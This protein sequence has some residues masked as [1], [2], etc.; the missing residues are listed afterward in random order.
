LL[1]RPAKIAI[2]VVGIERDK[3]QQ[4][5]AL[6]WG[7]TVHARTHTHTSSPNTGSLFYL[8]NISGHF[9]PLSKFAMSMVAHI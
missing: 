6:Y 8:T 2:L 5:V 7:L 4:T 9:P 1:Q 3:L